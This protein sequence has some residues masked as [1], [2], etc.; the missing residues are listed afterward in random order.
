MLTF[1]N[2]PTQPT[3]KHAADTLTP[4]LTTF[5]L[6]VTFP[7][8]II[9]GPPDAR[10]AILTL[11]RHCAPLTP[12][13]VER[14]REAFCSIKQ[15]HHEVATSYLNRIRLLT[16]D[17][18]H[19]GIPNTD[20]EL[21]KR[22]VRG[23]SNHSFYAASYQRFDADIRRAELNDEALPPFAELE[24]H[25][26]NIDES[27]GLTLPSQNHRN[28]NQHANAARGHHSH[29]FQPRHNQTTQR[30]FTQRQQQAF[31]SILRPYSNPSSNNQNRNQPPRPPQ[32]HSR[33]FRP[34]TNPSRPPFNNSNQRRPPPPSPR[35]SNQP[36]R[37]NRP[38]SDRRPVLINVHL[39]TDPTTTIRATLPMPLQSS[40][41]TAD[42]SATM[43]ATAQTPDQTKTI[44]PP[45][46][47]DH[48]T[49]KT[50]LPATNNA[51]FIT[52]S[53]QNSPDQSRY[54]HQAFSASSFDNTDGHPSNIPW[55][56][57]DLPQ[58]TIN[59]PLLDRDY[60]PSANYSPPNSGATAYF[61]DD[62]QSPYQRFGPHILKTGYLTVHQDVHHKGTTACHFT[63]D[64]G[65]K[66]ILGL[67]DVYYV[68]GLSHRLLSLTALSCTQNFSVLI[69]NRA[70]TIQL[71]N[72]STYTWPILTRELP[73]SQQAFSTISNS[74]LPSDPDSEPDEQHFDDTTPPVD[75]DQRRSVTALPLELIYRRLAFRN[76][77]NLMVGSLHQTWNDHVLTPT[78]DHNSWPLR[79]SISQKRA[80]NKTPQRQGTEPFHRLHLDLMRNPFRYGLT[81]NTNFSA[82]LFIVT[83]PGKLTGWI[84][85]PTES[86]AS[87]ITALKQWLTDTELLGR[88]QSVRFIR[89][90]AGSAFT[91]TK[92][93]SECTSLGIKVEAAAPEHQEMNGICEAKWR[94]V[95]NTANIL[96]NNARLGGAFF[97]HAHA[98]AVQIL[99]VCPAK[100]V[101]DQDGNPTTPY[102]YSFQ[103]KPSS[104]TSRLRMSNILQT[105]RT[106]LPQ[107]TYNLQATPTC[108]P[109]YF[110]WIS[111]NSA[112]WLIYSPDQPQSLI[113]TRDA[114]FDEDFNSALCFDSKPLLEPYPSAPTSI[115]MDFVTPENSEP[116]TYH[117]TGSAANL[118][119]PPSTFIDTSNH[120][121][122]SLPSLKLMT[123]PMKMIHH[124]LHLLQSNIQL[125]HM[126]QHHPH[127][128]K[129]T[130]SPINNIIPNSTR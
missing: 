46:L 124:L 25:L 35:P 27:R 72:G 65:L 123:M 19:A 61:P 93:I 96:L 51:Y 62:P 128:I 76:F 6:F 52:D 85:L 18:Y 31:S 16:R 116:S 79:I 97:H 58:M 117:Q 24:S 43:R 122:S 74:N 8:H 64:D 40:A 71:P 70:T 49:M 90:D 130:L 89:T 53:G 100:N 55:P 87:I 94:E 29:H 41:I 103:R 44:A 21:I 23:G 12:D 101:I 5:E 69:K 114:Y 57:P 119:N 48:P 108:I 38:P 59:Q 33:P 20:A 54:H 98:Y 13:H 77:R 45:T 56:N 110:P 73:S 99:N 11:R 81:T 15:P 129:S 92:F 83:T 88:T 14:T 1:A 78:V 67:T 9:D 80:R 3:F 102:Q 75:T 107:Q 4:S 111:D 106:N 66:S 105:L 34:P 28:Y 126:V 42:A 26:L 50:L 17:C 36:Q 91:S 2:W 63:T 120:H 84:G 22:T 60:L 109:R 112:G 104:P 32:N 47:K 7:K 10:T 68:E 37:N 125:L 82:Y 115:R 127:H 113:I 121:S 86:T 30:V 39:L 95:H 118:G